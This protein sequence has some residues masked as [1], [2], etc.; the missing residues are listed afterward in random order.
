MSRGDGARLAGVGGRAGTKKAG[1]DA[2]V[3]CIRYLSLD[4][5]TLYFIRCKL[6]IM[7]IYRTKFGISDGSVAITESTIWPT[8][9]PSGLASE[10]KAVADVRWRSENQRSL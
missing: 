5:R 7:E 2:T 8:A 1:I 4:T 9:P 10:I 6:T 3:D